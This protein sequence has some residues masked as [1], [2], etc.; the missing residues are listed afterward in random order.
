MKSQTSVGEKNHGET[1]EIAAEIPLPL[2]D[3]GLQCGLFQLIAVRFSLE[4]CRKPLLTV[5]CHFHR[6][7]RHLPRM[8]EVT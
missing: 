4:H 6:I 5:S 7:A 3:K 1:S 2:V 8:A